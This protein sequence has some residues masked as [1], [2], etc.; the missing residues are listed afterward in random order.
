MLEDHSPS[1]RSSNRKPF[2]RKASK[3]VIFNNS[4]IYYQ[5][6]ST[7]YDTS[8]DDQDDEGAEPL[9]IEGQIDEFDQQ[10]SEAEPPGTAIEEKINTLQR[11]Q[12][13][14]AELDA[15]IDKE[16]DA[17]HPNPRIGIENDVSGTDSFTMCKS[18]LS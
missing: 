15:L 2:R 11:R 7:S 5:L 6:E 3:T 14:L 16:L 12:D 18:N 17:P 10:A 1:S 4:C 9:V 8:D 13:D